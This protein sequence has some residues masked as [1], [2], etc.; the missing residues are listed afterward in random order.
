MFELLGGA[1]ANAGYGKGRSR[2][3]E[4][5]PREARSTLPT[6]YVVVRRELADK[7][8]SKEDAWGVG[9]NIALLLR[10]CRPARGSGVRVHLQFRQLVQ[11][12]PRS[13]PSES[14]SFGFPTT[15]IARHAVES[16]R[17][18][19]VR[20]CP[21]RRS[22]HQGRGT[23]GKRTAYLLVQHVIYTSRNR[24]VAAIEQSQSLL[25][26]RVPKKQLPSLLNPSGNLRNTLAG[27]R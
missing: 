1:C 16:P 19:A 10:D 3:R 7:D 15:T 26:G 12:R 2:R 5:A 20:A 18:T 23:I 25:T 4:G 24:I 17:G 22:A 21:F 27:T 14:A 8:V 13:W 6:E 9:G 11:R